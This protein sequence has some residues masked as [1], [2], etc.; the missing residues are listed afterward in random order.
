MR[1]QVVN[2]GNDRPGRVALAGGNRLQIARQLQHA[3]HE[4]RDGFQGPVNDV[5]EQALGQLL[6]V[7]G[8]QADPRQL[9]HHQ[10]AVHLMERRDAC[11]QQ[12][13]VTVGLAVRLQRSPGAVQCLE[14]IALDPVEREV[15][16][17]LTHSLSWRSCKVLVR[18]LLKR[19]QAA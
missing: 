3:L 17:I 1:S 8:Q 12:R 11:A 19:A 16:L 2:Q 5:V 18:G 14:Q 10:R 4:V 6:H 15:F 7:V 9:Q 13:L